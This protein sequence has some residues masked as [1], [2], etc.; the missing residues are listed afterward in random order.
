MLLG[1]Q[2]PLSEKHMEVIALTNTLLQG[3]QQASTIENTKGGQYYA[4]SYDS[5]LDFFA[6]IS[7]YTSE[8]KIQSAFS[9]AYEE[10]RILALANLLYTLSIRSGKGERRI[11]L[12]CF[13]WLC[14][15]HA[16]S[17]VVML[18]LIPEYGR[19]DYVLTAMHTPVEYEAVNMI[20]RQL[21]TDTHSDNP[22]LLA[23]W[24]PSVRTHGKN[25]PEARYLANALGMSEKQYRK[26]LS[27]LR[28]KINVVEKMMS[29]NRFED[30]D[31]ETVP[32]KAM[33]KYREAW[34]RQDESRYSQ[35]LDAVKSGEKKINTA[36]L[37]C[38][39]IVK[40]AH[41][42]L[43]SD[44]YCDRGGQQ[45][46]SEEEQL[47]DL[48]WKNQKD[49]LAGNKTN[50]L[51]MAD[52]SGSM[53]C[54]GGLPMANSLG[55]AVYTAE[56]NH[57]YFHNYFMSFSERPALQKVR[58]ETIVEKLKNIKS[59]IG[60]TDIDAAFK[61][62]LDTAV[63]NSIPK[64]DMPSHIIII[65]DMEFDCGVMSKGGTNLHGWEDAFEEAGYKLPT[66]IFWNVAADINGFPAT[67]NDK[68][69]CMISGFSTAIL[70]HLLDLENYSPVNTMMEVLCK[71]ESIIRDV[72][73]HRCGEVEI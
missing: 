15:R 61:M 2:P 11:F 38:Y 46:S 14:H 6:G 21:Y 73:R 68:N 36:G 58:G 44:W 56:R 66:I 43:Y 55:L 63:N 20:S 41:V 69:V 17:A 29:E 59:I 19:W 52:T 4:T 26:M 72:A 51:V 10:D 24:L 50:V 40:K 25:N 48:M 18:S 37:F 7:R 54:C 28:G 34:Q 8:E 30:I 33:L 57:G 35:Y 23:K 71:Y 49:F 5:N 67:K 60:K 13:K 31:Y 47:L 27:E 16:D 42:S 70:E 32:T 22:S 65:S 1:L 64:N 12:E 45:N 9:A 3:L 39:E 62:L 53:T